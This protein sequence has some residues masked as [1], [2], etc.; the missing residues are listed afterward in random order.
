[1]VEKNYA[2]QE[3][4]A[5]MKANLSRALKAGF[6]YE[7]IFIEY[8]IIEDRCSSLLNHAGVKST[9]KDGRPY[10]LNKKLNILTNGKAFNEKYIR[11]R[12]TIELIEDLRSWKEDRN[13][14]IHAL[15]KIQYNSE[16][17]N[18]IAQRGQELVRVLDNKTKSVNHYFQQKEDNQ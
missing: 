2:K 1:M 8:A 4:Y 7:A 14:L 10:S 12:I 15:A 5:N 11:K 18:K 13:K 17:V 9:E 16:S 6:Y 3:T